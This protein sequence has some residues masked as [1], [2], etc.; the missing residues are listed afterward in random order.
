MDNYNSYYIFIQNYPFTT[1]APVDGVAA[2][3][4]NIYHTNKYV[5]YTNILSKKYIWHAI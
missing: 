3:A 1:G 2:S 4:S 5:L